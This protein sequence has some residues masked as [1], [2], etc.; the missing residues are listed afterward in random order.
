[1]TLFNKEHAKHY[2]PED[3]AAAIVM[4]MVVIVGAT[5]IFG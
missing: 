3:F 2:R 5:L 1:M 4:F